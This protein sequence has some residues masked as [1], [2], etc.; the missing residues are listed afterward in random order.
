M[1]RILKISL[2]L[3]L[4]L[5]FLISPHQIQP[6]DNKT[7]FLL[8]QNFVAFLVEGDFESAVGNFDLTMSRLSPPKKLKEVWELVIGQVGPFKKQS[9][10]RMETVPNY[11]IVF[12]T[13]VFEKQTLDIK[14]VFDK[15]KK[16]AGQFFVPTQ[17][18]AV[19]KIPPYVSLD[20]FKERDVVVG[21]GEWEIPGTLTLPINKDP[22]PAVV[23]VHGSGPNDR[24]ESIGP[25]KPFRDLAWGLATKGIAVLRYDKRTKVHGEKIATAVNLS[26]TVKEE[27]IDDCIQA[28]MLLRKESAIDNK[29]IFVLGHSLGGTLIPRIAEYDPDI[30]GFIILAGATRKLENIILEQLHYIY[31]LDGQISESEQDQ[32]DKTASVIEK[33][34]NLDKSQI[35]T[36]RE[37]LLGAYPEYWLDLRE[38][39]PAISVK[40]VLNPIFVLQGGRDYQVTREDFEGWKNSLSSRKNVVFKLYPNLNHLFISGSGKS[41]PSEYQKAGNVDKS[42]IDD[43][44]DWIKHN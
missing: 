40:T 35:E 33:I 31:S 1:K 19:Y 15:D 27:T 5:S 21:M 39:F 12:V 18:Q 44:A 37:I 23:L 6:E 28:V 24:D 32:L 36:K 29:R 9:G 10:I 8:A 3:F 11:D 20:S 26:F 34:Q 25:N 30:K 14:V 2:P 22:V 17:P 41:S 4:L 7:L 13:C 42:V 38:Y 43:I 16:I